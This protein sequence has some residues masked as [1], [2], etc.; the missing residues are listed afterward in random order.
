MQQPEDD[1][2]SWE[3]FYHPLRGNCIAFKPDQSRLAAMGGVRSI[4]LALVTEEGVV[5]P[6]EEDKDDNA[7]ATQGFRGQNPKK[8][9]HMIE[10]HRT[11]YSYQDGSFLRARQDSSFC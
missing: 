6:P 4:L 10:K 7:L 9:K 1:P 5:V 3:E 2:E 8:Q 11:L